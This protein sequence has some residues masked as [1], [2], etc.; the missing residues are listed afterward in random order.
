M[1]LDDFLNDIRCAQT[2]IMSLCLW[3]MKLDLL[4]KLNSTILLNWW[5]YFDNYFMILD[6]L[7]NITI[8][9]SFIPLSIVDLQN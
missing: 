5:I 9:Y 6:L 8:N 2:V 3:I 4:F 1:Q 7:L